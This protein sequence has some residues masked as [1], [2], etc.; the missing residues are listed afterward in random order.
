MRTRGLVPWLGLLLL[1]LCVTGCFAHVQRLPK[2]D[3]SVPSFPPLSEDR[4]TLVGVALS[5]G[6]SRAAYF[7]AS[8]LEALAKIL[9][10]PGQPSL[11]EQVTYLSSVSG[12][13]VASSY[14]ATQK[15]KVGV[16]MLNQDG[17]L[18][19]AYGRFFDEYRTAMSEN[20]QWSMNGGSL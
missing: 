14:F 16:A 18:T 2:A 1:P 4:D 7:G 15:P 9:P 11:L 5:G 13:S 20:L 12:G 19:P 3:P 8:A 6:G 10:E 17:S